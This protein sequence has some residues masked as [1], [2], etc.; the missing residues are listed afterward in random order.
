MGSLPSPK[1]LKRLL[2]ACKHRTSVAQIHALIILNGLFTPSSSSSFGGC[3]VASYVRVGDIALAHRV[4]DEMPCRGVDSWNA[5]IAAHS[6]RA[7][8]E[9]VLG[10]Y[11]RMVSEGVRPDS[12]TFAVAIKACTALN[13]LE[14]G[15]EVRR[16]AVECGYETDVFVGSSVLNMYVKMGMMDRASVLFEKMPRRDVVCWTT[17]VTGFAQSGKSKEALMMYQRMRREGI[18]GDGVVMVGLIR[19]CSGLRVLKPGLSVHGHLI[20]RVV[21]ASTVLQIQTGLID[22]YA[23][24]GRLDLASYVFRNTPNRNNPISWAAL[25][26]GFAQNGFTRNALE[27][28]I[29]MQSAGL[30]PNSASLVSALSACSQDGLLRLGR[31]VHGYILR[32]VDFDQIVGTAL[33]DFYSKCGALVS[34]RALFDRMIF[35]DPVSWNAMISSYGTHGL[36]KEALSVFL[37]MIET[38]QKPDHITFSSLLSALSHSGLVEEGRCWFDLMTAKYKIK[39]AEKHCACIVDLL[40]RAGKV[41]E[42]LHMINSMDTEP[43]LAVWVALL[44]GCY[45]HGEFLI[46]EVAANNILKLNPDDSGIYSLVSN[47]FAKEKKWFEVSR[48]RKMMKESL[49]KKV[50]GNSVVDVNGRFQAFIKED[51]SHD[52]HGVIEQVLDLL[53][54]EIREVAEDSIPELSTE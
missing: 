47:F 8:P 23:K 37:Q 32:R 35:R 49:V 28:F 3:L 12:S 5:L 39:P 29:E 52:Q 45:N 26:S 13:D 48:V 41:K 50:P 43:G 40:A 10:L 44:S 15:E 16:R 4:F 17:M 21:P 54:R 42:A 11:R 2:I 20:R 53:G 14:T 33:I 30:A 27:S 7:Y 51:N 34:A 25:I 31:S 38:N 18:E 46:G 36:G 9:Q 6:R 24:H 22:M 1:A 19:A